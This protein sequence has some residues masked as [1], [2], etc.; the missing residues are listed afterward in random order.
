[1]A[2]TGEFHPLCQW[3][4]GSSYVMSHDPPR[5]VQRLIL[6]GDLQQ[7]ETL[8]VSETTPFRIGRS[9]RQLLQAMPR[10][11]SKKEP[12]SRKTLPSKKQDTV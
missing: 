5:P 12:G 6:V 7:S 8:R 11:L 9:G 10:P 4:W 2:G 1:M 3:D